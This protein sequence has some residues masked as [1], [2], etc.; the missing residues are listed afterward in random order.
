MQTK[1][2]LLTKNL[3]LITIVV[4]I[5]SLLS[6]AQVSGLQ[7]TTTSEY[8]NYVQTYLNTSQGNVTY[9]EKPIFPVMINNSQIQIGENWT[10]I[11]PLQANH[12]YHIYFYGAYIN[13]SAQ[14]KTDYDIFVYDPQ[15]NLESS[16][17]ESAGL[18]PH[19]GTTTDDALFTPTQS[20]N[21][22][23]V[24]ENSPFGSQGAQQA[25]FMII[26]NIETDTW[27]TSYL[28]GVNDTTG[29]P[30]LYTSWAYEFVTNASQL[31]VYIKVPDTLNLYEARLYLMNDPT[32]PTLN[33]YPLAWEPGLYGNV[34]GS[35]GGYNFDPNGYRGAAYTS[36]EY[37]GQPL[38]LNYTT[39]SSGIHLYHLVLIGKEGSGNLDILLKTQFGDALTPS[40]V[41][42]KVYPNNPTIISYDASQ[43][44]NKASLSYTTDDWNNVTSLDME[45][46]NQ[47]C[48]ATIPGQKAGTNVQYKVIANDVLENNLTTSGNYTVKVQPTINITAVKDTIFIGENATVSGTLTNYDNN[49]LVTVQ[50]LSVNSTETINCPVEIDGNFTAS[51]KPD[52]TGEWAVAATSPE[53][54]TSWRADSLQLMITVSEPPFYV[55]YSLFLIIGAVVAAA[56]GG[57][58]WFLKFRNK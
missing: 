10:I 17:M 46:S 15:G 47:T 52:S 42:T 43:N 37:P 56:A 4:I 49:S 39:S 11:C 32:S 12:D 1:R 34:T 36:E 53:T 33:S 44:L 45:I 38:F 3:S 50:F 5:L 30:S 54:Q 7:L 57:A 22:S 23:F 19:L 28:E 24:I 48:N 26:E 27:Q 8:T 13:T 35:V 55:K 2:H 6:V 41:E 29:A 40:K 14:A 31:E 16:H 18:P 21:Y 9:V 51:F 25:T 58:V 20:G